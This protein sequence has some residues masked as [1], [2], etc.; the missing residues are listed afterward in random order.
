M[1]SKS[2]ISPPEGGSNT[3]NCPPWCDGEHP[4]DAGAVH[5]HEVGAACIDGK[6]VFVFLLQVPG[7]LR[8]PAAPVVAISGPVYVE[9]DAGRHD[10]VAT[11]LTLCGQ[12]ELADLV[13]RAAAVLGDGGEGR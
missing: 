5:S 11:L 12:N 8:S 10:G 9:I 13:R 6:R 1:R 7:R 4:A 3:G 2:V